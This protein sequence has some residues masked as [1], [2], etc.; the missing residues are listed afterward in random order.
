[1]YVSNLYSLGKNRIR[2]FI[3]LDYTRGFTRYTDEY[4]GII[5]DKGFTGF[6]NDSIRG[7]QRVRLSLESDVF[8]PVNYLGFRFVFFGFADMAFIAGTKQIISNG[9][10]L[11][12]IGLGI[13]IR[14]NNLVFNTFQI[15]IGFFPNAPEYSRESHFT[16]SGEQLLRPPT[17][18]PGPPAIIPFQ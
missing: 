16:I 17:F 8:S 15:R 7:G 11:S 4:L 10:F 13:R 12:G 1:M 2:N 6:R 3:N 9:A 14:N 18:V 5:R